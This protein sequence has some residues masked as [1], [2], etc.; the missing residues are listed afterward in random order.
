[1]FQGGFIWD[2]VDQSLWKKNRYG[3]KFLAYGGDF[4]DRPSDFQFSANGIVFGGDRNPKPQM[5][6]VKYLYQN[7]FCTLEE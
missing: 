3:E 2:Y 5:Q 4:S 1:M 6:E 7:I